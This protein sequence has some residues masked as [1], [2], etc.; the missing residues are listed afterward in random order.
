MKIG[1]KTFDDEKILKHFENEADFFEIMA[2]QKNDYS[3][4]KNFSLPMVIHAEHYDF[5]INPADISK[6]EQNLNSINFARKIADMVNAKKIVVHSGVL[7]EGNKNCSL[8]N[9][10]DFFREINDNRI[11]I[12]NLY[13][14]NNITRLCTT[15][16]KLKTFTQKT[17]YGSCF[18]INHA[19]DSIGNFNGDYNFILEY[20]KLNPSHYHIGG[21]NLLTGEGHLCFEKSNIDLRK[22][23]SY[24]PK[25]A[26][27]TLETEVGMEKLEKDV[28]TIKNL[29]KEL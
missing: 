16:E 20:V 2:V 22:I 8:K 29:I 15:P 6:R 23:L 7:E 25:N 26:E 19:I 18:D 10:I 9:A 24:Y 12:E 1:V 17:R 11:L 5:G 28:R 13:S 3:F 21:Q 27:I 14:Q 4:L